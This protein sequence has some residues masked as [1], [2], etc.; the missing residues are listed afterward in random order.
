[1]STDQALAVF[2]NFD[3]TPA[4]AYNTGGTVIYLAIP[5]IVQSDSF[6]AFS[7]SVTIK[8]GDNNIYPILG[9]SYENSWLRLDMS[10][11][12]NAVGAIT[13][14]YTSGVSG[15]FDT[16]LKPFSVTFTPKGLVPT[17]PDPPIPQTAINVNSEVIS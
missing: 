7:N 9:V 16:T 2:G 5:T 8:D 12:N 17:P 10:D 11:F 14:S 3:N 4:S 15:P 6:L 13:V 1:M